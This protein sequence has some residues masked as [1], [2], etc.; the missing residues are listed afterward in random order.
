MAVGFAREE[1]YIL[2][3]YYYSRGARSFPLCTIFVCRFHVLGWNGWGGVWFE[4]I[5]FVGCRLWVIVL[6][7]VGCRLWVYTY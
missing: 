1:L 6:S 3:I 4:C 7:F 5:D 2:G